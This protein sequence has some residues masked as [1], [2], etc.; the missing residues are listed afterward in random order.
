VGP[1]PERKRKDREGME[2]KGREDAGLGDLVTEL[3]TANKPKSRA[4]HASDTRV[5]RMSVLRLRDTITGVGGNDGRR[6]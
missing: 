3:Q 2:M 4:P 6:Q 5:Y 1:A